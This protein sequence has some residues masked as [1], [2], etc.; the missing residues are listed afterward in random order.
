MNLPELNRKLL[1]AARRDIP[2]EGVPYAFERR[3]MARLAAAP[4][5]DL[6]A[7]LVRPLWYG[8][9][10][11]AAVAVMLNVWSFHP[12]QGEEQHAFSRG[13]EDSLM[14]PSV[15]LELPW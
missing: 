7:A 3:V 1:A 10:A 2:G 5:P 6:W 12:T 9:A 13:V 8:A 15:D 14:A 4:K 11:C